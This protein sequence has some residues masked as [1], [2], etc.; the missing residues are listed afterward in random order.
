[1][2]HLTQE[3]LNSSL[4]VYQYEPTHRYKRDIDLC[5]NYVLPSLDQLLMSE[6]HLAFPR[7]LKFQLQLHVRFK[8]Y[9]AN[10]DDDA[11]E[12]RFIDPHFLTD[13]QLYN[14][15]I[16]ETDLATL[17]RDLVA[18]YD[19][20]VQTGSGWTL[21]EVL[22]VGIKIFRVRPLAGGG[23]QEEEEEEEMIEGSALLP[24]NIALRKACLTIKN[25]KQKCFIYC[26][27]AALHPVSPSRHPER[28]YHYRRY[29]DE[30]DLRGISFPT[31]LCD[32]RIFEK[33]NPN[34]SINVLGCVDKSNTIVPLYR[35]INHDQRC[36][37]IDLFLYRSHYYLINSLSRLLRSDRGHNGKAFYCHFCL[38]RY[39]TESRFRDHQSL[40]LNKLQR[41]TVSSQA[42]YST[43]DDRI[44][45]KNFKNMFTL[46]FVIYYDIEA[47]IVYNTK[48]KK[49]DHVPISVCTYT[50]CVNDQYSSESPVVFTGRDC[51]SLFVCHLDRE[52][53]RICSILRSVEY[54]IDM[55]SEDDER[56]ANTHRCEICNSLFDPTMR[57]KCRDH[58]HLLHNNNF[59]GAVCNTCNLTHGKTRFN[60][61]VVAHNAQNYDLNMVLTH[62]TNKTK[63]VTVLA[64]NRETF[65]SLN[66]GRCLRF[67]DSASFLPGSL[68]SMVKLLDSEQLKPFL[69]HITSDEDRLK[70]LRKKGIF[71]Y[72]YMNN[73]NKLNETSLPAREDFHNSLTN[74]PITDEDY[75]MAQ[76]MW[77][78]FDCKTIQ[79]YLELY[80]VLDTML[81]TGMVE[82]YR[83]TTLAHFKL[84]PMY[85]VSSA[86]MS[87]DA[88]LRVTKVK[89]DRLPTTDMYLFVT[90]SIRGGLCGTSTRYAKSNHDLCGDYNPIKENSHII[91]WD[92]NNLYGNS[93]C[94]PLPI[95]NFKWLT[96]R[97]LANFNI[98]EIPENATQGYFLEV[99]LKY[100]RDL[101]D[102]HNDLPLAPEKMDVPL[103]EWSQYTQRVSDRLHLKHKTSGLKLMVNLHDKTRYIIHHETLR[104]Y[105]R[106]GLE[107]KRVHRG[108]R[109]TQS[110]F[111]KPYILLNNRARAKSSSPFE[112]QLYKFY[113]NAV[114]GKTLYNVFKQVN[115][116]LARDEKTFQRL[117]ARPNFQGARTI[118]K[119]LVSVEMKPT[120]VVC[121]KPIY[122]GASVLD[123]SK[124]HMYSFLYDFLL[125]R[126]SNCSLLYYD[127]DSFY[128]Q[129]KNQPDLY[130]TI[131]ECE[132]FFDRSSYPKHHFLHS[133]SRKQQLGLFK[134]VHAGDVITELVALRSKMYAVRMLKDQDDLKAKG[135]K[136]HLVKD[137]TVDRYHQCLMQCETTHHTY[138]QIRRFKHHLVTQK[139]SKVG[140]SPYEDKRYVLPCGIHTLAYGHYRI[141][142]TQPIECNLCDGID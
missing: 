84:D 50:K 70:L 35:S 127:T 121:D 110:P 10:D 30:L 140:L 100:P 37:T 48:T 134:D 112:N 122:I 108:I 9:I 116:K 64:K 105:L 18:K 76:L 57:K 139:S 63:N 71:P 97:E 87:M 131:L 11:T 45:F 117:A 77:R 24:P 114:F 42:T 1:M 124:K 101:H 8:K 115:I 68:D 21:Q 88:M 26:C 15:A 7:Q 27:L 58:N 125:P 49:D 33:N 128:L 23:N 17:S 59:R 4:R 91:G 72:D 137:L 69:L 95:G 78:E 81:L 132:H 106:Q 25:T 34:L 123:L 90:K 83:I 142:D 28:I 85:Y 52:E 55:D 130:Q 38:C 12:V 29:V 61:P 16:H 19:N 126:Y 109:F 138:K 98:A 66:Y 47:L 43:M 73:E 2:F 113:N 44:E 62:L 51:V 40:C 89:L 135:L 99:D 93:L 60:I 6:S 133:D 104:F 80:L 136:R 32:I 31:R 96:P 5:L 74:S 129:I 75:D 54:D 94:Q 3:A 53:T 46:P 79:D 86:S 65:L 141:N 107:L 102:L 119:D 120:T 67:I 36:K 92:A 82:A 14:P 56:F 118:T 39:P 103:H 111:L 22:Q 41:L 20:F 13:N